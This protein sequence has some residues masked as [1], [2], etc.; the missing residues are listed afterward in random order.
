MCAAAN[1]SL[2]EMRGHSRQMLAR[3][4]NGLQGLTGSNG[5]RVGDIWKKDEPRLREFKRVL[6]YYQGGLFGLVKWSP[7]TLAYIIPSSSIQ[8]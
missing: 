2:V 3:I 1:T 8:N 5:T 4:A 6:R 7:R